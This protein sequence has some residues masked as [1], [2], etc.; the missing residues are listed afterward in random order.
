MRYQVTDPDDD[1]GRSDRFTG[2]CFSLK[3]RDCKRSGFHDQTPGFPGIVA[4]SIIQ[5][6]A[7]CVME[8]VGKGGVSSVFLTGFFTFFSGRKKG[9]MVEFTLDLYEMI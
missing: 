1:S 2:R 6:E 4:Q 7:E 5:P 3:Y 8:L 9:K